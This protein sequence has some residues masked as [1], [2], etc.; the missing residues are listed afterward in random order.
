M[1]LRQ[2]NELPKRIMFGSVVDDE[3]SANITGN[4]N[5]NAD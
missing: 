2:R 5:T 1:L 3:V 4:Y